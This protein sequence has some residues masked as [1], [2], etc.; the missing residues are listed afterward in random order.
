MM[1]APTD[2]T[3]GLQLCRVMSIRDRPDFRSA[4]GPDGRLMTRNEFLRTVPFNRQIV[5]VRP[6][7]EAVAY[8]GDFLAKNIRSTIKGERNLPCYSETKAGQCLFSPP[9]CDSI[10]ES[11]TQRRIASLYSGGAHASTDIAAGPGVDRTRASDR[12]SQSRQSY[13][14]GVGSFTGRDG[15]TLQYDE[16]DVEEVEDEEE[17]H[18][19]QEELDGEDDW[20]MVRVSVDK[21]NDDA[22]A[23]LSRRSYNG[24]AQNAG[25][26]RSATT[27][28]TGERRA[29]Q[30]QAYPDRSFSYAQMDDVTLGPADSPLA[31]LYN[32]YKHTMTNGTQQ[33]MIRCKV[34]PID[35]DDSQTRFYA[36]CAVEH[37]NTNIETIRVFG[38]L[39]FQERYAAVID[40]LPLQDMVMI[41]L[42]EPSRAVGVTD[43]IAFDTRILT[44]E[45]HRIRPLFLNQDALP[46]G[47][48][49]L[50]ILPTEPISLVVD[51]NGLRT[52][53]QP[54]F[55]S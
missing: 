27:K 17:E 22:V 49:A 26:E 37:P 53:N 43:K 1:S 50:Y 54:T 55:Y 35:V 48:E 47:T 31:V 51:E 15:P 19:Q 5:V 6:N 18:Q 11:F 3:N 52:I 30:Q 23:D 28:A 32:L 42:G 16:T 38:P 25:H 41:D 34:S 39:R 7:N 14:D 12:Q 4:V 44:M 21:G 20:V 10:R 36:Y 2:V 29:T 13:R 9:D 45:G 8:D 33:P 40:R 24:R 46:S